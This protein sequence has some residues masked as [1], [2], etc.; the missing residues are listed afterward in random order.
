[1][2]SVTAPKDSSKLASAAEELV[3][4]ACSHVQ[5]TSLKMSNETVETLKSLSIGSSSIGKS[6]ESIKT[7]IAVNMTALDQSISNLQ[8]EVVKLNAKIVFQTKC[9]NLEWAISN[10]G[11]NAFKY[12]LK[13]EGC[14][15][16]ES[17]IF[18]KWVLLSFRTGK[19]HYITN[20]SM[21]QYSYLESDILEG[22]RQFREALSD[23]IHELI[24]QKPRI[25]LADDGYAIYYS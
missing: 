25:A 6:V 3:K 18:V 15:E 14:R 11:I 7:L 10:V 1:M 5:S 8:N 19:G 17:T 13:S 20:R 16:I 12:F 24:G 23:Q 9:Q 4:A 22:E 2:T 21:K